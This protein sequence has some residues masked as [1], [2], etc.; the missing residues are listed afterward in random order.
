MNNS[1]SCLELFL[2]GFDWENRDK[3]LDD[4]PLM[5]SLKVVIGK[6]TVEVSYHTTKGNSFSPSQL[7]NC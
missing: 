7:V 4:F 6:E 3:M 5:G 2:N 1:S